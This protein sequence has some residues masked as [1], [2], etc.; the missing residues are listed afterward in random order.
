MS[1]FGVPEDRVLAV[2]ELSS[3]PQAAASFAELFDSV[4]LALVLGPDGDGIVW[5][6]GVHPESGAMRKV[7]LGRAGEP[8]ARAAL[9]W[10]EALRPRDRRH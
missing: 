6:H 1:E 5:L 7:N 4:Q 9:R 2:L 10:R 3:R 8:L